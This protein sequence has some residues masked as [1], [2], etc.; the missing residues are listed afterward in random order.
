MNQLRIDV[1]RPTKN[2]FLV[3]ARQRANELFEKNG[4][5]PITVDDIRPLIQIPEFIDGRI[6]GKVFN[7]KDWEP[8]GYVKSERPENHGR[9]IC[10]FTRKW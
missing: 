8:V 9:P 5:Q 7:R 6:M 3:E 10:K 1:D 4:R 2:A